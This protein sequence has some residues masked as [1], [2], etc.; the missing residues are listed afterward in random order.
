[1]YDAIR[2]QGHLNQTFQDRFAGLHTEQQ[3]AGTTLLAGT[4]P[5]QGTLYGVL[6][7]LLQLGLVLFSL[8]T[9]GAK[10]REETAERS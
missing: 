9:S 2:V 1:M 4:V 5:D 10:A 7:Q 6:L 3:E 8:E